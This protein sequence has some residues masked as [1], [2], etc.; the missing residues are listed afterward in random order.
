MGRLLKK[1]S[2]ARRSRIATEAYWHGTPQGDDERATTQTA[3]F[4][5]PVS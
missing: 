5:Q 1:A 2:D 3:L 4:Q